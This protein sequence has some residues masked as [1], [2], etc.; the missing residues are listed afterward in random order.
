MCIQLTR[1]FITG[2]E[3]KFDLLPKT[4]FPL[5]ESSMYERFGEALPE[6]YTARRMLFQACQ[7]GLITAK[8]LD[9]IREMCIRYVNLSH[10]LPVTTH[11][12]LLTGLSK[13][14]V[15]VRIFTLQ[16]ITQLFTPF[17]RWPIASL[18][19]L[20]CLFRSKFSHQSTRKIT[21]KLGSLLRYLV[22]TQFMICCMNG[23]VVE[24]IDALSQRGWCMFT[25]TH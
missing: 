15:T 19:F 11:Q 5:S 14:S 1:A 16:M 10:F 12:K 22:H 18:F 17:Q 9:Y 24:Y 3:Q 23:G 7:K 4:E 21:I 2:N 13:H 6:W 8:S 25:G 20:I